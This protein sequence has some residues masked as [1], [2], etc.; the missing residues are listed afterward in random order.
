MSV[1]SRRHATQKRYAFGCEEVWYFRRICIC[2][3]GWCWQVIACELSR[4]E[5]LTSKLKDTNS[6]NP[7][8]KHQLLL[9]PSWCEKWAYVGTLFI[10]LDFGGP[11]QCYR[12]SFLEIATFLVK[13]SPLHTNTID[14]SEANWFFFFHLSLRLKDVEGCCCGGEE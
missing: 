13:F 6:K 5:M 2:L 10:K 8:V 7:V 4:W 11:S 9:V 3:R 14:R 1:Q 12:L